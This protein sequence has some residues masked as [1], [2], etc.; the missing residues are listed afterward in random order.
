MPRRSSIA[1]VLVL[2]AGFTVWCSRLEPSA[3]R[4]G[5]TATAARKDRGASEVELARGTEPSPSARA[6]GDPQ[7]AASFEALRE[8][9]DTILLQLQRAGTEEPVPG[10]EV[11]VLELDD[12]EWYRERAPD[13]SQVQ[14]VEAELRARG[15]PVACDAQGRVRF[16][17]PRR[18]LLVS[19]RKGELFGAEILDADAAPEH[20][21]EL[22]PTR[23]CRVRTLS[24]SGRLLAGIPIVLREPDDSFWRATSDAAGEVRVPNLEWLVNDAV[25]RDCSWSVEVEEAA[26][27]P[28]VR[29]FG[30][31]AAVPDSIDLVLPDAGALDLRLV[32]ADGTELALDGW[33]RVYV[34]SVADHR[35]AVDPDGRHLPEFVLQDGRSALPRVEPDA[36]LLVVARLDGGPEFQ[37]RVRTP[38]AGARAEVALTL[39]ERLRALV[40]HAV[41]DRG[42]DL[43]DR[44]LAWTTWSETNGAAGQTEVDVEVVN[45]VHTDAHG[46]AV[47]VLETLQEPVPADDEADAP[48]PQPARR[49]AVLRL[50]GPDA[51]LASAVLALDTLG[52]GPVR[53]LGAIVLAPETPLVHGHVR[54]DLGRPI[55]HAW[56]TA[57][58]LRVDDGVESTE[59]MPDVDAVES[60]LD[61]SFALYGSHPGERLQLT[62]ERTGFSLPAGAKPFTCEP[63][64][65]AA[66]DLV[67]ARCG[68]L[69]MSVVID[70]R[71]AEA[72]VWTATSAGEQEREFVGMGQGPGEVE[73]ELWHLAP[74]TWRVRLGGTDPSQPPIAEVD[75]VVVRPG[76]RTRDPRLLRIALAGS[77]SASGDPASIGRPPPRV[78]TLHVVDRARRPIET[79]LLVTWGYDNWNRTRFQDGAIEWKSDGEE[80]EIG[81]WAPGCR[82]WRGRCG[83]HD[84]TVV[85]SPALALRLAL[86]VPAAAR[87]ADVRWLLAFERAGDES[88]LH[89][90]PEFASSNEFD[91][92]GELRLECP[93]PA[94]LHAKL[95]AVRL[96]PAGTLPLAE[97]ELERVL[98]I[99]VADEP[100]EQHGALVLAP[101]EWATLAKELGLDR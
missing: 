82:F 65:A 38:P 30:H 14:D 95:R 91:A 88:D 28:V 42:Q 54:D 37:A 33:I 39:P 79:G 96:D 100:G 50:Q 15:R 3:Q 57:H 72:A 26:A 86:D 80:H 92:H 4:P 68:S 21:L 85:L 77:N 84:D 70:G 25:H 69:C 58:R 76:E 45:R 35:V 62:A 55:A 32:A 97:A 83:A 61:G 1:V 74:G 87:R 22:L 73:S 29:R 93:A 48:A 10:A 56:V 7:L 90:L 44:A 11:F 63:H 67:L 81:V 49:K 41:D 43:A 13:G 20:T 27:E 78:V 99:E 16:D 2:L 75:G 64:A 60:E 9:P 6:S 31:D 36:W 46:R 40:L 59:L 66:V 98:A 18:A 34:L 101:E 52:S 24:A 12:W 19:A 23:T 53:D 71:L 5:P 8:L 94:S 51:H 47:L 89:W 17:P